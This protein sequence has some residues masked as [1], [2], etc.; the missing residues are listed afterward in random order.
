MELTGETRLFT[1][2]P[3]DLAAELAA[4]TY[5]PVIRDDLIA[6]IEAA[7]LRGRGGAGFPA[8]VKWRAVAAN[9]GPRVVVANGEEGEPASRKDRWLLTHR[10]HLVLDGLLLAARAVGAARAVVYL[11]HADTV[12]AVE[13]ALA[14]RPPAMPVDVHVV[15][16]TYVAGEESAACRS[17]GGGPA[18]PL[19]KPPRVCDAGVDGR[20]TLVS[21][22]ETLAHAAWIARHGAAAYRG[23]GTPGSPGTTLVTLSGAVAAPGVYEV[24]FGP[25]LAELFDVA[26]GFT[27]TPAGFVM[28]GWFGGLLGPRHTGLR[29]TYED[30]RA[31]GSGLG[32]GAVTALAA[33]QDPL[34]VAAEITAWYAAESAGQCG[35]C[36]RGTAAIRDAFA[37]LRD[38]AA[39]AKDRADLARWGE[40][41]PGR[42]ACAFLDG[43]AGW[44]RTVLTEF[45]GVTI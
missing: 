37:A 9:P 27:G 2:E 39:S 4:G 3:M 16:P 43:A 15:A 32:C 21:N 31:A 41:L 10:P 36:V 38:G 17:I 13:A 5:G 26:G 14:E 25:T 34:A 23:Q 7:G 22:V 1:R 42:G 6:E 19:A 12:A 8:H 33:D 44:A 30:V 35:V 29:V 40:T 20:P 24:P 28:G 45:E 18:L 11:S